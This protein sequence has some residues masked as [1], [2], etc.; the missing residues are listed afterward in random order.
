MIHNSVNCYAIIIL[1]LLD[2]MTEQD[3]DREEWATSDETLEEDSDS[4]PAMAESSLDRLACALGGKT[5]LPI[6]I[7]QVQVLLGSAEWEKRYAGL[8]AVSAVGEGCS[9]QMETVLDRVI[10]PILNFL[11]DAVS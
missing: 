8:M 10:D 5:V 4:N 7:Q 11:K 3:D 9:K 1:Q 6:V 2:M